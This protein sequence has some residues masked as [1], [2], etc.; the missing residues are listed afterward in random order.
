MN[1][2]AVVGRFFNSQNFE[3]VFD[4]LNDG[5]E[6]G[7]ITYTKFEADKW[8]GRPD[9]NINGY[10]YIVTAPK[11]VDKPFIHIKANEDEDDIVDKI[12]ELGAQLNATKNPSNTASSNSVNDVSV[13]RSNTGDTRPDLNRLLHIEVDLN[14]KS[15]VLN[16]ED[17]EYLKVIMELC[18]EHNFKIKEVICE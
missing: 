11:I 13:G 15:A 12:N 9:P 5:V 1:N 6:E 8:N 3:I 10:I 2:I 18:K 7:K 4:M 14:G 17:L 16:K